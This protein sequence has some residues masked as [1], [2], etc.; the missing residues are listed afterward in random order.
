[1]SEM[2]GCQNKD[3]KAIFV[4]KCIF[5]ANNN[6]LKNNIMKFFIPA[7]IVVIIFCVS[8]VFGQG[9]TELKDGEDSQINGMLV[10]Y[11]VVKKET[12]RGVIYT[13]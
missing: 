4:D 5:T 9:F 7:I 12:K 11:S 10:S 3:L 13:D 8:P 1:M 2:Q 6:K